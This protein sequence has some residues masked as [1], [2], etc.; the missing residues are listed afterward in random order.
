MTQAAS[1]AAAHWGGTI[2][3]LICNRENAV[4]EMAL[5]QGRAA[6]RLH[7]AGYQHPDAIRSELW[8]TAALAAAGVAVPAPL[9]SLSGDLL[10]TLAN[11]HRAS[12]ITWVPGDPLGQAGVALP[13]PPETTIARHHALGRLIADVHRITDTLTLPAWFTRAC[14]DADGLTGDAPFWGRFWDHP[15]LT[16]TESAA[17]HEARHFLRAWLVARPDLR[18]GPIHADVLRENV[19][20]QGQHLSLI[21]FDDAGI[22]YRLYDLGT[23]LS[24]N[25]YEPAYP[26]IRDALLDGYGTGT[27]AEAEV[28]TLARTLA[29]VGWA[30]PRLPPDDPIHRSHIDRALMWARHVVR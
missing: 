6:L 22:G 21:D 23:V 4:Y 27:I 19:L 26:A 12:A 3:R 5:P 17:L 14:W 1:A 10:V 29:S 16:A 2:T 24:Q 25:L 15:A 18:Q 8:W 9:A 30:A 20:V 28:F 7:R 13:D 11:G